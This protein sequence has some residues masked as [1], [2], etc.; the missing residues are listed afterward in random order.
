[1]V[2]EID[3]AIANISDDIFVG[4]QNYTFAT[5]AVYV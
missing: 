2:N 4:T 1:M 3:V 5:L